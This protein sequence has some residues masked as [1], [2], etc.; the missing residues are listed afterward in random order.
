MLSLSP[1]DAAALA[2]DFNRVWNNAGIS[3]SAGRSAGLYCLFDRALDVATRDPEDVR[4]RHID[5][6]LPEGRDAQALR[7]LMSEIEM[8]LFE[9]AVNARRAMQGLPVVNGFWLWGGGVPLASLPKVRG[10]SAGEDVFFDA[11][12]ADESGDDES[13]GKVITVRASPGS[14]DWAQVESQWLEP[15]LQN[16]KSGRISRLVLSGGS[17][18][19]SVSARGGWRFWRRPTPWWESFG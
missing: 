16:L 6:Y 7:R 11:F 1:Q 15:A 17:V 8:W 2:A 10:T 13:G 18:C 12:K 4:G 19:F 5:G 14:D 9:H 3:L